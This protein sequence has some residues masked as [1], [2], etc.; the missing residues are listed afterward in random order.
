[1]TAWLPVLIAL[2]AAVV[3]G[4]AG[5]MLRQLRSGGRIRGRL[6]PGG[7]SAEATL[8]RFALGSLRR[9]WDFRRRHQITAALPAGLE[10]ISRSLRSGASLPGALEEAAAA[11]PPALGHE[12]ARMARELSLGRSATE[13]LNGFLQRQPSADVRLATAA[14]GLAVEAGG[15]RSRALDG[16]AQSIRDRQALRVE[17][18]ALAS[19]ARMSAVVMAVLPIGFLAATA[20]SDEEVA[21]LLTSTRLGALCLGAGIGLDLVGL[22]WMQTMVRRS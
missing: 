3:V 2:Q 13:S 11:A 19:Q 20:V 12:L 5:M 18:R 16:L 8:P 4:G 15:A 17:V 21:R 7:G 22:C 14:L 1:M 9:L 6:M 10:A